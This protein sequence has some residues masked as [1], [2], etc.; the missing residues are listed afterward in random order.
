MLDEV[1]G[2]QSVNRP[3]SDNEGGLQI[4]I[5][6][7]VLFLEDMILKENKKWCSLSTKRPIYI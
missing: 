7:M 5:S 3:N 1:D 4:V 6:L 2:V